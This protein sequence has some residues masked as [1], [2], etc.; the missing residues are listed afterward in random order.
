VVLAHAV[1]KES[2]H[3]ESVAS[4]D[5]SHDDGL[6]HH[7]VEEEKVATRPRVYLSP[8]ELLALFSPR[9]DVKR[10]TLRPSFASTVTAGNASTSSSSSSSTTVKRISGS[11]VDM[12]NNGDALFALKKQQHVAALPFDGSVSREC[13]EL[14]GIEAGGAFDLLLLLDDFSSL[15]PLSEREVRDIHQR[16]LLI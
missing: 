15:L 16:Y 13:Y 5:A 1:R 9:D 8:K 11:G 7:H 10:V 2:F 4:D 14:G 12:D 6:L 3:E